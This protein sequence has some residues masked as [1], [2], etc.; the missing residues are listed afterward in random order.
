MYLH[1]SADEELTDQDVRKKNVVVTSEKSFEF[2]F[3][4]IFVVG[5]PRLSRVL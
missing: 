5:N 2:F 1:S 3:S 4:R